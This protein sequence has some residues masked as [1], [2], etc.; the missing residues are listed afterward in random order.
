M[1]E[2]GFALSI[3]DIGEL[4]ELF[5]LHNGM[6]NAKARLKYRGRK[7]PCPL[8]R[9]QSIVWHNKMLPKFHLSFITFTIFWSKPSRNQGW[10]T[11]P[12]FQGTAMNP[13]FHKNLKSAKSFLKKDKIWYRPVKELMF[14]FLCKFVY[15]FLYFLFLSS[16]KNE[17]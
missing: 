5:V 10:K 14:L 15:I 11:D 12:N 1:A 13:G 16:F 4:V 6:E 17:K 8:K 2:L 9:Q 3:S 7:G